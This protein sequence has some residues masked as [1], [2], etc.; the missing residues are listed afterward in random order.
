[1][2]ELYE[3]PIIDAVDQEFTCSLN[4]KRCRFRV[5]FNEWSGRWTFAL[6]IQDV[7]VLTGR[8]IVTGVDLVG[9]FHFG[10]GKIVCMHWDQGNLEPDRENLPSGRVRLFQITE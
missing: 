5:M 2:A 4:D 9:P 7:L 1:M 6:W 3:L 8:R 10:I